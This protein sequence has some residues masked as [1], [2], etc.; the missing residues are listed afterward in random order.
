MKTHQLTSEETDIINTILDAAERDIDYNIDQHHPLSVLDE[1]CREI[2]PTW[3]ISQKMNSSRFSQ[4]QTVSPSRKSSYSNENYSIRN[5]ESNMTPSKMT[6]DNIEIPSGSPIT[7][8]SSPKTPVSS[9]T[10]QSS[11]SPT[12]TTSTNKI[13]SNLELE[14]MKKDIDALYFRIH[15]PA[16]LATAVNQEQN[17][18]SRSN[19]YRSNSN[20]VTPQRDTTPRTERNISSSPSN[21]EVMRLQ[22]ENNALRTEID[23]LKALLKS[24]DD[25]ILSLQAQIRRSPFH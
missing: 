23:N 18:P 24:K 14:E 8:I 20:T 16:Q 15:S 1:Q 21:S 6:V 12:S 3:S 4:P 13:S 11:R 25:Q 10:N 22:A 2:W 7:K 9:H 5:Q 19:S 17:S